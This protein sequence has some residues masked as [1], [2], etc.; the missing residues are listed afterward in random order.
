MT[1]LTRRRGEIL[2]AAAA[3]F[4]REGYR[5]TSMREVATAAGIQAGSLY[6]HFPSKE[7]IAVELVQEYHADLDRTVQDFGPG[8]VPGGPGS[9]A[10]GRLGPVAALRAF[11]RDVAEV[12]GR[13]RAALQISMYDAPTSASLSLKTVV[14]AESASLNEHWRSLI[15]GAIAA[16]AID[17]RID[18]H[19]LRHVLRDT[20]P[21]AGVMVWERG[22][23]DGGMAAVA[24]CVTSIILDGLAAPEPAPPEYSGDSAAIGVVTE[25]RARW[26]AQAR[27]RLQER[28]GMI[29]DVA[30][31]QF[32][33]RG[34]EATT[35]RDIADA[36]GLSAGNLYRYF[37]SKDAMVTAI[38]SEFSDRLLAAYQEVLT[39]G[40][41]AVESLEAICLLLDQAGREFSR[42]IDMLKGNGKVLSLDV[43]SHYRHGAR[44][45]YALLVSL[46][47]NGVAT[48]EVRRAGEAALVASCVREIMWAP[49]RSL[50]P[51]SP[52]RVREFIR[53]A[54][55][56]GAARPR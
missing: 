55:L 39:I 51:I 9:V 41:S 48:G 31:T 18:P 45:R 12:S 4:A 7:A 44:A 36:A 13:N 24:D 1:A 35:M 49:M 56:A 17:Q 16:G 54:I 43:A 11:A 21:M 25:A 37:G 23:P 5:G 38:L 22:A 30:R 53:R 42:E 20:L 46:I 14:R 40:T 29:L 32:A 26:A 8:R 52:A 10:A 19:I 28:P 2:D 34:F 27:A 50:A 3:L 47:E 15:G 33:Q 6:H